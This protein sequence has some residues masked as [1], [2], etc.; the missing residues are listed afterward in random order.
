MGDNMSLNKQNSG[1][2]YNM[3]KLWETPAAGAEIFYEGVANEVLAAVKSDLKS[4][5]VTAADRTKLETTQSHVEMLLRHF[6]GNQE[7]EP[8]K[9]KSIQDALSGLWS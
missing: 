6:Q 2:R 1:F 7:L 4:A 8:A 3:A 9:I 5:A